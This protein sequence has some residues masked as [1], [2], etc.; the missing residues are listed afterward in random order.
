MN[1]I[2]VT[3]RDEV[4]ELIQ[5]MIILECNVVQGLQTHFNYRFI[6]YKKK[7]IV[8]GIEKGATMFR[9]TFKKFHTTYLHK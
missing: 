1:V 7:F 9:Y 8:F 4:S 2:L 3:Q 5:K 6:I